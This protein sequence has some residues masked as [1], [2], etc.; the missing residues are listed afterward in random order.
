MK[1]KQ[2]KTKIAVPPTKYFLCNDFIYNFSFS[3]QGM[4]SI[5][6]ELRF[7]FLFFR[8]IPKYIKGKELLH[9]FL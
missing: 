3:I 4:S 8:R 5:S 7:L 6:F 9:T 2:Q 1:T